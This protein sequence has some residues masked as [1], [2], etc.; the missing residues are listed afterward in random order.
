MKLNFT[1]SFQDF[2]REWKG[3]ERIQPLDNGDWNRPLA[4]NKA[5]EQIFANQLSF[6]GC[7]KTSSIKHQLFT[8]IDTE[9]SETDTATFR[10]FNATNGATITTYDTVNIFNPSSYLFANEGSV[11]PSEVTRIVS[12]ITNR[13][14]VYVQ[15]LISIT[16]KLK[17]LAGIR[18]SYQE[19]KPITI[20]LSDDTQTSEKT[21]ID[22][23][24]T[25]KMGFIYQPNKLTSFFGSFANS[26]IPNT[27][28]TIFDE[29]I[30]P[31]IINQ[32]EMGVK[33]EWFNGKL[34]TNATLYHI[35]NSNLAQT[36]EFDA[37]GNTNTNTN[38]KAL[39]GETTS[40]G[41][42]LET[43]YHATNELRIMAG[44]S[45]NDMR[46]TKTSGKTGSFIEGDRLVRT[47]VHTANA[48]FFYTFQSGKLKN[49]SIGAISNYIGNRIGGWNNQIDPT[50]PNGIWDRAIPIQ[51]YTTLD[52]S[53]GY[54]YKKITLLCKI[55]NLTN[56]LNYTVHENY[57]INPI[58]PRQIMS[59]LRYQF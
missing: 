27:G 47:P 5:T 29:V 14:G 24:F 52:L 9:K 53:L 37:N 48:S 30:A 51:G 25:P 57:S 36:A 4:Q 11:P 10:F 22:R 16:Q 59:S 33:K 19:A 13:Y 38:V 26:F 1:A 43:E 42:E 44:Y 40:K 7:F 12:T 45:Y 28:V 50:K 15:D 49:L 58:A 54:S 6:Q 41:I 39:S 21:R 56:E 35:M 34:T 3:T 32:Y 46:Y 23:A 18:Y 2:S 8:G 55:S 20:N 17:V 31:S